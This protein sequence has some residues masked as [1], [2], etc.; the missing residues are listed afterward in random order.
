MATEN[1]LLRRSA[2]ANADLT[3][4]QFFLVK[5]SSGKIVLAD[6][7]A[8]AFALQNKP[9]SGQIADLALVG[10][11]KVVYGGDVN[12]GDYLSSDG[13]GKAVVATANHSTTTAVNG[14]RS[15]GIALVAGAAG[16]VGEM[17]AGIG[18]A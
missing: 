16:D 1:I 17:L 3:A 18:L 5:Y 13:T 4:K 14:T 9:A 15:V 12:A 2:V 6:A 10:A 8:N 11:T 7:G